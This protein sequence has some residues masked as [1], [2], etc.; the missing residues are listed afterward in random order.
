MMKANQKIQKVCLSFL[1]IIAMVI[2]GMNSGESRK[3]YA[4]V[5]VKGYTIAT[6]NTR[7]YSNPGLTIGKGWIYPSDEVILN[8]I[9]NSYCYVTYPINGGGTKSGYIATSTMLLSTNSISKTATAKITTYRRDNSSQSYGYVSKGDSVLI[10]GTRGNYTQIRYPVSGG[11]KFAFISTTNA[12]RYLVSNSSGSS[13]HSSNSASVTYAPYTGVNYTNVGLSSA[14]VACLNKAVKMATI[15]WR[16]PVSFRTWQ[17]A[18]GGYNYAKATDGTYSTYFVAGKTYTGIPYSM[19][20][21]TYDETRWGELVK[22]GFSSLY[23]QTSYGGRPCT[24]AHGTD[25]SYFTYLCFKS[26]GTSINIT[27]QTTYQMMK[28]SYYS[29]KTLNSIKGG[30]ILLKSAHVM[31]YV[32]KSGSKYAVIEADAGDSKVTYNVY[33]A[34]SLSGYGVYKFK[35]FSD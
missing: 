26:A 7:V 30:D 12:N 6:S 33:T 19:A 31:L 22:N 28:S 13:G 27:Y 15:Q 16:C 3:F 20:D 4:A 21:H 34:S 35:G 10:L 23:M 11:Y 5:T 1:L 9:T 2:S 24:T 14:R 32:G 8:K 17:A 29:K 18:S 25:C